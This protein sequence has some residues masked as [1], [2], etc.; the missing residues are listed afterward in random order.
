MFNVDFLNQLKIM[1]DQ[2]SKNGYCLFNNIFDEINLN[3]LENEFTNCLKDFK[4]AKISK[5]LSKTENI[6]IRS[7]KNIWL[8]NHNNKFQPLWTLL[9]KIS[10]SLKRDL[11][12]PIKRYE[13]Q[14]ALYSAGDFYKRH[15]DK[16]KLMPSRLIS[17]VF[18]LSPWD[19][20]FGGELVIYKNKPVTIF[21]QKNSLILFL[22][23]LEH[24]VLPTQADRK[25]ITSWFRDDIL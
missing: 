22:S 23:E 9:D 21:P 6:E 14:L 7:D 8:D 17:S 2:I 15:M 18:Y 4:P 10:D 19:K 25:S 3:K 13:S 20:N 16:H 12:L 24:E 1:P 11:Y 5:G